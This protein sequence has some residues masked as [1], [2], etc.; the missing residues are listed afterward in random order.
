MKII[1]RWFLLSFGYR[2]VIVSGNVI[3][4]YEMERA[5]FTGAK[6]KKRVG[7]IDEGIKEDR[8]EERRKQT[9]RDARNNVRRLALTNFN[10]NSKFITLTFK[11]N[12][13]DIDEANKIFKKFVRYLRKYIEK[14]KYVAVIEFQKRGAIH[15]HM[16]CNIPYIKHSVLLDYWRRSGSDGSVNIQGIKH[17]DNVGAYITS[18][19][20]KNAGDPRLKG[21]KM[22]LCS[23]GLDKPKE[24]NSYSAELIINEYIKEGKKVVFTN[25]YESEH[26]GQIVYKEYNL[27]RD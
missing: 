27:K 8:K 20:M 7:E 3:E 18:Y 10:D 9:A 19:M 26:L 23:K 14:I 1:S 15:Y 17:V 11:E 21:K 2:K 22:Y 13:T 25:S 5:P 12:M 4:V 24:Y 16:L 6:S